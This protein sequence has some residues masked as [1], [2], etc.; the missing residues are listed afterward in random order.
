[1]LGRFEHVNKS[2]AQI[3]KLLGE[4]VGHEEIARFWGEKEYNPRVRKLVQR[5]RKSFQAFYG[6]TEIEVLKKKLR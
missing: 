2:Y 1:M 6:E 3:I 5:A 4:G